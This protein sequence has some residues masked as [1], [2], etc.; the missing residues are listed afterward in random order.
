MGKEWIFKGNIDSYFKQLF[1]FQLQAEDWGEE[2]YIKMAKNKN[3]HCGITSLASYPL[4]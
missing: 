1:F 2:G 4:V 3:N